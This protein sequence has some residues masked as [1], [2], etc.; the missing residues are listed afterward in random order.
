MIYPLSFTVSN[1]FA[2]R[3]HSCKKRC[4]GSGGDN[5]STFSITLC[6]VVGVFLGIRKLF[7]GL[8]FEKPLD[9]PT[10]LALNSL[11]CTCITSH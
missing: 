9:S 5:A 4:T 8:L 1:L 7:D 2:F 6:C 3:G 10:E 11:H